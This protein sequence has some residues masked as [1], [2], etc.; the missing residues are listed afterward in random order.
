MK[1][2]KP[3]QYGFGIKAFG[4]AG[5]TWL[6][7]TIPVF[8]DLA[9]PEAILTEQEMWS[10]LPEQ[11]GKDT[12]PDMG[13]PKSC[14]ELLVTGSCFTGEKVDVLATEVQVQIG[15]LNKKLHVYGDR[16][17]SSSGIPTRPKA[18]TE[19][20]LNWQNSY[21][22]ENY[23][24]NPRG[25]GYSHATSLEERTYLPLPNIENPAKLIGSVSDRPDP[26]CFAPMDL[27]WPQRF[28]KCG[29]YDKSWLEERWPW[30]P[31]DFNPQ[32][33]NTAP[34]DQWIDGFFQGEESIE[35]INMH[36]QFSSIRSRL[37]GQRPRCFVTR[38]KELKPDAETE[39]VEVH[40]QI[41]TVWLFPSVLRGVVFYRGT[42][43]VLDD[44]YGD[45]ERIYV[46]A[47]KMS[48][49]PKSI[50][51]YY[52]EQKKFWDRT[53]DID[54]APL[55]NAQS[56][57][58]TM[59][60]KM[61]QMPKKIE[62]NKQKAMGKAPRMQRTP[63]E[64]AATAKMN[65]VTT[66]KVLDEQEALARSMHAKYGHMMEFDLGMFDRMRQKQA[67][68]TKSIDQTLAKVQK[69][70]ENA[71]IKKA[72]LAAKIKKQVPKKY[73]DAA[74]VNPD[75]LLPAKKVNPWHDYGFP[76]VIGWRKNMEN[77]QHISKELI[78]LGFEP[79]TIKKGW[80]GLNL[81]TY[82][83]EMGNWGEEQQGVEILPALVMPRFH[84]ATLIA[85]RLRSVITSPENDIL[86]PGS[87][88]T[89]LFL[90]A[91]DELAPLIIVRDEL[92]AWLVEQEIGDCCSVLSMKDCALQP[93]DETKESLEQCETILV[94]MDEDEVDTISQWQELFPQA[95]PAILPENNELYTLHQ[96]IGIRPWLMEQLPVEIARNN[97]VDLQL[98]KQGEMLKDSPVAGLAIPKFDVKKMVQD[99]SD[100]L[101]AFHQPKIDAAE[102]KKAEAI[103]KAKGLL[104]KAGQD[105]EQA[106]A[107]TADPV[108]PVEAGKSMS[109]KLLAQK[110]NLKSVGQLTPELDKKISEA[111]NK[112][113]E[114]G[115]AGQ[116]QYDDGMAKLAGA[117]KQIAKVKG[118]ELPD[119]IKAKFAEKGVDPDTLKK[120]SRE[121]VQARYEQGISLVGA[122]LSEV[123][124]SEMDLSGAD[125]SKVQC[126][127][128]IFTNCNLQNTKFL[129]TIGTEADFS[130]AD[131]RNCHMDKAIFNKSDFTEAQFENANLI[132]TV[133]KDASFEGVVAD[134][135]HFYL[136]VLQK[137]NL[138]RASFKNSNI[139]MTL[140]ADAK[141]T[142]ASFVGAR[143]FK[144]LFKRTVL[145]Q[146]DF[147]D[148]S[149]VQT[150]FHG[151]Q[152]EGVSFKGADLTK[153]RI[154]GEAQFPKADFTGITMEQGSFIDSNLEGAD[155]RGA[156]IGSSLLENCNF[157]QANM[158]GVSAQK[159]KLKRS[160]FT[161]ANMRGI[162]LFGGSLKKAILIETDL[163]GANLF[164]V[165]FFKCTMGNTLL[166]GANMKRTL[167]HK[168]T[169]YLK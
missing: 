40:H 107:K 112:A 125:L 101:K 138:G 2:Y 18:F 15:T 144:C 127:K 46:A 122:N 147:S 115:L 73:L 123:D 100:E 106:F 38:R 90:P 151:A 135:V 17:W 14:G 78:D 126:R 9:N 111:A 133:F 56:K 59:L 91:M 47:E 169:E 149:T 155:F 63:A 55:E 43:E 57:I 94:V 25:K 21:G 137:A 157:Q 74:G 161:R 153:G 109:N 99:F 79:E 108:S 70:S 83:E 158:A 104:I 35:L 76:K 143:L 152:G 87:T 77:D 50:E 121:E 51:H 44:E 132:Q 165:D 102:L 52:E 10:V 88:L 31:D 49:T 64:I 72:D 20:A 3:K 69:V 85:V 105:P 89:P 120:L 131:L 81:E 113:E 19:I 66:A 114:M 71:D 39:F 117:K 23:L 5:K 58:S 33:F 118:G 134:G 146:A 141:A 145:D 80:L 86:I 95:E 37:P 26:A 53:V 162:N 92:H 156:H 167:L 36:P 124:L 154:A 142:A 54:L 128:T 4:M 16:E 8:F 11:L 27:M 97:I 62:L 163:T 61:H 7:T 29:T 68:L 119:S 116:K 103:E 24:K 129:Q 12:T 139:E 164:G 110:K 130:G 60:K 98:P 148:C 166:D 32:F 65:L 84:E 67:Q 30:F 22:G 48:D 6:T 136:S 75:D 150:L 93:D 82:I 160:N 140:L 96:E 1:T 42:L 168:R 159:S 45:I 34:T 13:F 28:D 41:D